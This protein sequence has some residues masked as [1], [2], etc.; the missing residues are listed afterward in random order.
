MGAWGTGIGI[1]DN[2]AGD[3]L[4]TLVEEEGMDI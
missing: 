2:D 3:W 4:Y 1:F